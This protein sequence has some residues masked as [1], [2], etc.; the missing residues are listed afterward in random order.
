MLK[1]QL[2]ASPAEVVRT[3]S[4]KTK[5]QSLYLCPLQKNK[6]QEQVRYD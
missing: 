4:V 1:N 5:A 3:G 6:K 2:N